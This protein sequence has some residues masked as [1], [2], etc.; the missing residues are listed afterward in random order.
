V[1]KGVSKAVDHL[2]KEIAPALLVSQGSFLLF[3]WLVLLAVLRAALH[4][5]LGPVQHVPQGGLE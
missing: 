5:C 1:G 4:G 2:N 3:L